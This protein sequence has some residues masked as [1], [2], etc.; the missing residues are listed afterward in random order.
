MLYYKGNQHSFVLSANKEAK[1]VI[2]KGGA[3]RGFG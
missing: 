1:T 2:S 3:D